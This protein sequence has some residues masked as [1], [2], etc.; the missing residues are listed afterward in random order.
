MDIKQLMF[1]KAA[2]GSEP[3]TEEATATGNP[4]T[5]TTDIRK[6]LQA[7]EVTFTP[8]QTGSGDPAPDNVRNISGKS[9]IKV[10][11]SDGESTP[12]DYT[13]SLGDT[14]YGGKLNVL[15]GVLTVEWILMSAAWGTFKTGSPD[16][17]TG[18][19]G[20]TLTFP[21]AVKQ[22][23]SPSVYGTD[24]LCNVTNTIYWNGA[25]KTPEHFYIYNS[26]AYVYGNF[27]DSQVIQ[28]AVKLAEPVTVQLTGQ[29][30]MDLLGANSIAADTNG[31]VTLT[32]LKIK[33]E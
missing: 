13:T 4:A 30:V 25:S 20:G 31:T 22:C 5:F 8:A 16:E 33:S 28:L 7:L 24:V 2:T 32:Y 6:P 29:Q 1:L 10:S 23:T 12:T 14:Y 26:K 15:T 21:S 27:D 17:T 18:F 3:E 19:Y 11:V 9:S